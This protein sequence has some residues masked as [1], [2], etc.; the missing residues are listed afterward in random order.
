MAIPFAPLTHSGGNA[1]SPSADPKKLLVSFTNPGSAGLYQGIAGN[2]QHVPGNQGMG[3][4]LH[5]ID[6]GHLLPSKGLEDHPPPQTAQTRAAAW[7]NV[8]TWFNQLVGVGGSRVV[9]F[10][11]KASQAQ[12]TGGTDPTQQGIPY[13]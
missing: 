2:M 11:N 5:V 3:S 6:Y 8:A 1:I 9:S 10:T 4:T 12:A 7:A 13:G